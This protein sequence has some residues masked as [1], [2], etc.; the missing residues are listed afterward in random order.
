MTK[1]GPISSAGRD[2]RIQLG[3]TGRILRK[4]KGAFAGSCGSICVISEPRQHAG[5]DVEAEVLLVAQSVP[6][7]IY[8]GPHHSG[9]L[10]A[11]INVR[12]RRA[13]A[14]RH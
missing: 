6:A 9:C 14:A 3:Y 7:W 10:P 11:G 13:G 2:G 12:S 5:E 8:T 4:L 1:Q